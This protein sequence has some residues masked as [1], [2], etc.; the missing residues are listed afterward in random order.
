MTQA[1]Q[2]IPALLSRLR[3]AVAG[4]PIVLPAGRREI[5]DFA[6][7]CEAH[8]PADIDAIILG[9]LAAQARTAPLALHS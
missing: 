5:R 1:N 2:P 8:Q 4:S 6:D 9:W 3:A 7:W